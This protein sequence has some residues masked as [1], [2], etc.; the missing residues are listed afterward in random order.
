MHVKKRMRTLTKGF[1]LDLGQ[2]EDGLKDLSEKKV[3]RRREKG[4]LS[5]KK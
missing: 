3:F 2:K 1:D 4:F 5:R